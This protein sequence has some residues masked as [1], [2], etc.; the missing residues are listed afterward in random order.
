MII[1]KILVIVIKIAIIIIIGSSQSLQ[2]LIPTLAVANA[3][4]P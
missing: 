2:E 3:R 1:L 4:L